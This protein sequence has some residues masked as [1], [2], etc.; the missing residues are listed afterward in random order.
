VAPAEVRRG[1]GAVSDLQRISLVASVEVRKEDKTLGGFAAGLTPE[2]VAEETVESAPGNAEGQYPVAA[3]GEG[4][5]ASP[6]A[7]AATAGKTSSLP[8]VARG[9]SSASTGAGMA[10][11]SC[12][13]FAAA[14][15]AD[16]DL[17]NADSSTLDCSII[18][19]TLGENF[20]PDQNSP[21][22]LL[23]SGP[24]AAE[25]LDSS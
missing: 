13:S 5:A 21:A 4:E 1:E 22:S 20:T 10:A 19:F 9:P 23:M 18:S 14:A 15:G 2:G 12:G 17:M 11:V 3:A 16:K 7:G 6:A 24:F 25:F 8:V